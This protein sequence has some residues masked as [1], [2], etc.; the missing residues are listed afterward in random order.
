M[1]QGGAQNAHDV[2][3]LH[4]QASTTPIHRRTK[5]VHLQFS[6]VSSGKGHT[7]YERSSECQGLPVRAGAILQTV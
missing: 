2:C 5:G 3:S 4:K 1:H 7:C 6:L